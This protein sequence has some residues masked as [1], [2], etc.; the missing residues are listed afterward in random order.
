MAVPKTSVH[1]DCFSARGKDEIR[2]TGQIS[3]VK[4]ETIAQLVNQAAHDQLRL[5]ILLS[6]PSHAPANDV[7]H[8][9]ESDPLYR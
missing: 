1:E 8:I 6:Y 3:A 5:G 2:A 7:G 4:P 9:V